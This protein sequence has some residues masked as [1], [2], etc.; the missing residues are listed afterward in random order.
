MRQ[1]FVISNTGADGTSNLNV[2]LSKFNRLVIYE[3][4]IPYTFYNIYS[5]NQLFNINGDSFNIPI[6]NY[7]INTLK[8]QIESQSGGT[9]ITFDTTTYKT[10]ISRSANFTIV[11]TPF[12]ELLG[13]DSTQTLTG[14]ST[15][16]GTNVF[17]LNKHVNNLFVKSINLYNTLNYKPLGRDNQT[18]GFITNITS[19]N[20]SFGNVITNF[21]SRDI[22]LPI[23]TNSTNIPSVSCEL[24][25]YNGNSISLNGQDMLLFCYIE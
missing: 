11:Y 12:L 14:L 8:T 17:N 18:E 19:G 13:F 6:K 24:S 4:S 7:N 10:T 1:Y 9:T 21:N 16:T 2:D 25:D 3:W 20:F 5:Y 23:H 22:E 15:Y